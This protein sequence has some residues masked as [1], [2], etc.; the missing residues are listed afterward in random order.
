[1][2]KKLL[3]AVAMLSLVMTGQVNAAIEIVITEFTDTAR[4]VAI[5]PFKYNGASIKPADIESIVAADLT[6]SGKFRP[7]DESIF[8]GQY[9]T[10]DNEVDHAAWASAGAEAIIVGEI[11][12]VAIDR[13]EVRFQVIDVIRG[14]ITGGQNQILVNGKLINS[15]DHILYT[16]VKTISGNQFR[17][18]AHRISDVFYEQLTGMKGAFLTQIAYIAVADPNTN[19]LPYRL[20]ISDYDGHNETVL[21]RSPEPLMSPSWSPDG[22]KLAYVSFEN[23]KSEIFLH[24]IYTQKRTKLTS[25]P[26]IN[27][28]PVFSPDGS[29]LAMVLSKDGNSEIYIMD[30]ATRQMRR[31]TNNRNIDTE[32]AWLPDGQSLIFS[33]ER[34]GKPQIYRV[35]LATGKVKRLTYQ[36]EMNLGGTVTPDGRHVVMVNQTRGNFHIARLDTETG[37]IQVLS[38]TYLDES[39]SLAPNGSMIIYSTIDKGRKVLSLVSLDGRFKATLPSVEGQVK[40][41]SWSPFLL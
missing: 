31:V 34:G 39:P 19:E 12:E 17:Q 40:S 24:D 10:N 1:M 21:L 13:F 32:P 2:F 29:K 11:N 3:T 14:Q 27:G 16:G 9:P 7:L 5:V 30:I 37:M 41:P 6:N 28:A 25:F 8:P 36:G 33:S 35:N 15:S 23:K 38:R 18:M 22:N 26:G 4:P 20:V